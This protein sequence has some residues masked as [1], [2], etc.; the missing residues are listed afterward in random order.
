MRE[1]EGQMTNNHLECLT[2]PQ[3]F[4]GNIFGITL[5]DDHLIINLLRY[6]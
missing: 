4:H 5:L 3:H 2:L 6:N 1:E